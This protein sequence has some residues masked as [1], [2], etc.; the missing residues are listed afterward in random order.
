MNFNFYRWAT[1]CLVCSVFLF[2]TVGIA[3]AQ[4]ADSQYPVRSIKMIV[5]FA[6]GGAMDV[7]A[8]VFT[9]YM[10]SRLGQTVFIEN[11]AG[12]GGNIGMGMAAKAPA[13]GYTILLV[14]N[15]IVIN[16][17]LYAS[18]PYD[19]KRSFAPIVNL[20]GAPTLLIANIKSEH[21]TVRQLVQ[22][23]KAKP[24]VFNYTS[25]GIGTSQH[26]AGELFSQSTG[27]SWTHIPFNG[28][29]P[30]VAAVVGNEVEY[31]FSS[32]PAASPFIKSGQIRALAV[33]TSSRFP[34]MSG[35]PTFVE[36]GYPEIVVEYFQALLAPAG[37]PPQIV[38]RISEV[39]ND[40]LK[41]PEV[42]KRLIE[43]GFTIIGGTP[44]EFS[45]QIDKELIKWKKVV[46]AS[47]AKAE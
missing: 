1:I 44:N 34:E 3:K 13:D 10:S 15:S 18:V 24:G 36:E 30:S 47:G 16:P 41:M 46:Q 29:G 38:A 4:S 2:K 43:M 23:M 8:R 33:T 7:F 45:D 35:V 14:S 5:P 22:A 17:S 39:S 32:L 42:S 37:T 40:I 11:K 9:K 20:V 27:A 26:L 28:A 6:P 25:S 12:A 21:R 31:G 19:A